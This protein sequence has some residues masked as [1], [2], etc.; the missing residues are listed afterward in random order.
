MATKTE[1]IAEK[2]AKGMT[3]VKAAI[4]VADED[5]AA[6][7][8]KLKAREKREQKRIDTAAVEIIKTRFPD[9]WTQA[10]D[11]AREEITGTRTAQ[12]DVAP[13]VETETEVV[14]TAVPEMA[15]TVLDTSDPYPEM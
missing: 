5:H 11:A 1:R 4:A 14:E 9:V 3:E 7:I 15:P 2:V 6:T 8:K 10:Q 13:A 12:E